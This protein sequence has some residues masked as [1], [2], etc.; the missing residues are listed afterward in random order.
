MEVVLP[1]AGDL[2]VQARPPQL[3]FLAVPRPLLLACE[4][5]IEPPELSEARAESL[6]GSTTR[7]SDPSWMPAALFKPRSTPTTSAAFTTGF[8]STM[9]RSRSTA[10]ET[11]QR[12]ARRRTVAERMR[13]AK[14]RSRQVSFKR[15]RPIFGSRRCRSSSVT[16][17]SRAESRCAMPG[18]RTVRNQKGAVCVLEIWNVIRSLRAREAAER[19]A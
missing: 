18:C 7:V 10:S 16:P 15:T 8:G 14:P 2:V 19:F 11:N 17:Y 4:L 3:R 1:L 9:S 12:S 13:P 5:T 6:C